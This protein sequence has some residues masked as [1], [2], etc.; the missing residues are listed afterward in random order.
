M[1]TAVLRLFAL[2]TLALSAAAQ[3]ANSAHTLKLDEGA[4]PPPARLDGFAW[5]AGHWVGTGF[6]GAH[7]EEIWTAPEGTSM[8]GMF[9]LV[10]KGAAQVYE[11]CVLLPVDQTVELRLK[12][13]TRELKG[14]EEKADHVTFRLVRV[15]PGE[16]CF[17]GLTFR[18]DDGG[19][20]V[21]VW[22]VTK[23]RAGEVAEQEMIFRRRA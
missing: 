18:L 13:F 9:R 1:K 21:R 16:A 23:S 5:L 15:A 20:T 12:H 11:L 19:A 7:V 8:S 14:W 2:V 4:A 22:L 3:S 6:G 10:S 17:E